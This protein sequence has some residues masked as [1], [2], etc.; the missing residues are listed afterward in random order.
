MLPV[1]EIPGPE[2]L[3][4]LGVIHRLGPDPVGFG[5][6]VYQEYGPIARFRVVDEWFVQV[7]SAELVEQVFV[8]HAKR[9]HKGSTY[10]YFRP[11]LG[12]GLVTSEEPLWR[13]RRRLVAPAFTPRHIQVYAEQICQTASSW[14]AQLEEGELELHG[15]MLEL[16]QQVVLQ[17]LFGEHLEEHGAEVGRA[18]DVALNH[19]ASEVQGIHQLLPGWLSTPARRRC[20]DALERLDTAVHALIR[21]RRKAGLGDDLLSRLLAAKDESDAGLDD[22]ALRDEVVTLFAAGHETTALVLTYTFLLLGQHPEALTALRA[23]VD[24]VQGALDAAGWKQLPYTVAVVREAMRVMPPVSAV[25][26]Q[27]IEPVEVGGYE[28][29]VGC[30]LLVAI[31]A[32]HRD[33]R[34][35]EEPD[36]FVPERWLD[37]LHVRL[38][39]SAYVPFAG[40]ARGCVGSH[41]A[42]METVLL[43]GELV[44]ALSVEPT[45]AFPPK[46]I[47]S[48][49]MRPAGPVP[50]RVR[51]R[52][53]GR[54]PPTPLA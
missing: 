39:R 24:A 4:G 26:R 49:T 36:R 13:R 27:P 53:S 38:P 45:G 19:A 6:E 17:T 47:S 54:P 52:S 14:V 22:E 12:T 28:I 33:P 35:F 16:S 42:M 25:V 44:R 9:M 46:V 7:A 10:E 48:M 23:E 37:G 3:P 2:G 50:A 20:A 40:G 1:T 43:L 34:W 5:R 32:M 11:L 41:Y 30:Q 29:P 18:V 51:R 15:A 21:A 8:T 31:E